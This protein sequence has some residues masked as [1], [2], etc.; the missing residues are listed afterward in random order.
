MQCIIKNN[1]RMAE[2]SR[3]SQNRLKYLKKKKNA[4]M[5]L[6]PCKSIQKL[7]F[8]L[9]FF[10]EFGR[11]Y[12]YIENNATT[13]SILCSI[14]EGKSTFCIY[15]V[16]NCHETAEKST[17]PRFGLRATTAPTSSHET[18]QFTKRKH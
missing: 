14:L 3:T 6:T 16:R 2:K 9:W 10:S 12:N 8:C 18:S 4:F 15:M 5:S 17:P 7:S 1:N 13:P 11:S